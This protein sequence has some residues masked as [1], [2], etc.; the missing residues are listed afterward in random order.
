M[1]YCRQIFSHIDTSLSARI[2]A[3]YD[4]V[5]VPMY[6]RIIYMLSRGAVSDRGSSGAASG[7]CWS[8]SMAISTALPWRYQTT[9][10]HHRSDSVQG[11]SPLTSPCRPEQQT[12]LIAPLGF[13]MV[14]LYPWRF[15]PAIHPIFLS[16]DRKSVFVYVLVSQEMSYIWSVEKKILSLITYFIY[17]SLLLC[18][19][20]PM[21]FTDIF[22]DSVSDIISNVRHF[23]EE[24]KLD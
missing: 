11:V 7:W 20:R 21:A 8:D 1:G 22:N 4:T 24:I 16:T 19:M 3:V 5:A 6:F 12:A 13:C 23:I 17:D 10:S 18:F 9:T 2:I 14:C 15:R